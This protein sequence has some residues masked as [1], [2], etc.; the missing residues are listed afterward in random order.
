MEMQFIFLCIMSVSPFF[1]SFKNMPLANWLHCHRCRIL[2]FIGLYLG[3]LFY[4]T[5]LLSILVPT[6]SCQCSIFL[7]LGLYKLKE[8]C[9]KYH[10]T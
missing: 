3:S 7:K 4:S 9:W 8:Q 5:G 1:H 6:A 10:N 2:V